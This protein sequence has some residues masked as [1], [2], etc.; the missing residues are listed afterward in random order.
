MARIQFSVQFRRDFNVV[1]K[2]LAEVA[3]EPVARK[4]NLDV[5]RSV[6]QLAD[7]PGIGAPRRKIGARIRML[8]VS[9][10]LI[11]YEGG[12]KAKSVTVLRIID[13]RR[14]ITRRT[15]AAGRDAPRD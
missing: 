3:G 6:R 7:N 8:V 14:R 13:G 1:I 4:Y 10:Y 9:P 2:R 15:I 11:F 5:R 12:P